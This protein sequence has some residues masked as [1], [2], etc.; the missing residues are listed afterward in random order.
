[1]M[2]SS[3]QI[4]YLLIAHF[5]SCFVLQSDVMASQKGKHLSWLLLHSAIYI[6]SLF[7]MMLLGILLFEDWT[8]S[9]VWRLII[10]NV[11][12][13]TS[14]DFIMSRINNESKETKQYYMLSIG[15]GF[16]QLAH[17]MILI[18]ALSYLKS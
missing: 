10:I 6:C 5:I 8:W 2:V 17:A 1:M 9:M 14:I 12:T 7:F 18:L 3:S 4:I 11:A 15:L 16:E 13:Y